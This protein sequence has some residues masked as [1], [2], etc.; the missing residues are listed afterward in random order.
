MGGLASLLIVGGGLDALRSSAII[1]GGPFAVIGALAIVGMC[2]EF[3]RIR[4][5]LQTNTDDQSAEIDEQ[6][7]PVFAT[8]TDDDD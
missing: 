5:V 3:Q 2:L 6:S 8:N 1:T 7:P 4:P